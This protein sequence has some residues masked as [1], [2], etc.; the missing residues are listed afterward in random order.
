MLSKIKLVEIEIHSYC[1]R[2]C[3][4]C[5]NHFMER[6]TYEELPSYLYI[7]TLNQLEYSNFSGVISFSKYNEPLYNY[8]LLSDYSKL[9]RDILHGIKLVASTNGDFLDDKI[10]E[11]LNNGSIVLDELEVVDYDNRGED[12]C[13]NKLKRL[14]ADI[15]RVEYPFIEGTVGNTKIIYYVD[16]PKNTRPCDRG[17]LLDLPDKMLRTNRCIEPK[18]SISIDYNGNVMPCCNLRSDNYDHEPYILGNLK[19]DDLIS[20]YNSDQAQLFR[21]VASNINDRMPCMAAP[22]VFCEKEPNRYT[23]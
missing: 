16:W 17:G 22:C 1:N 11:M 23:S 21:R 20:I 9:A 3:V 13:F 12:F 5:P 19:E 6:N 14:G 4:W 18:Y 2:R 15:T 10:I 7:D 8:R